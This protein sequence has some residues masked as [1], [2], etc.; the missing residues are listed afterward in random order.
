MS[1]QAQSPRVAFRLPAGLGGAMVSAIGA[2][3]LAD[4]TVSGEQWSAFAAFVWSI[5]RDSAGVPGQIVAPEAIW[6]LADPPWSRVGPMGYGKVGWLIPEPSGDSLWLVGLWPPGSETIVRLGRDNSAPALTTLIGYSDG[7]QD[8]WQSWSGGG[9]LIDL[10]ILRS[11]PPGAADGDGFVLITETTAGPES[12]RSDT[13]SRA[14]AEGLRFVDSAG[15]VGQTRRYR[16][17][18]QC[19]AETSAFVAAPLITISPHWNISLSDNEIDLTVGSG[20]DTVGK[21]VLTNLDSDSLLVGMA[22]EIFLR[23]GLAA[24]L[25]S[26]PMVLRATPD[27]LLLAAG[28]AGTVYLLSDSDHFDPG[29]YAGWLRLEVRGVG[30]P[31]RDRWSVPVRA[32][33]DA[34]TGVLDSMSG[35][36]K[37]RDF[38]LEARAQPNPWSDRLT[39]DITLPDNL[40]PD[41][42]D[43]GSAPAPVAALEVA[44][45]NILGVEVARASPQFVQGLSR[46][47]DGLHT[48]VD[49]PRSRAWPS[50]VYFCRVRWGR[51]SKIVPV[52]RIR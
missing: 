15:V 36:F 51:Y 35:W 46:D 14:F 8:A 28:S 48:S 39:I 25:Q 33:V 10:V 5:H 7:G 50:G 20:S 49:F 38:T 40:L 1:D 4:D 31:F 23:S 9:L 19:A 52:V 37:P 13:V 45:F 44:V 43:G 2:Y 3:F 30:A 21:L 32:T 47:H 27:T 42:A 26:D 12:P 34:Q 24:S 18:S 41:G 6:D 11:Q 16:V 22:P 17:A 29:E